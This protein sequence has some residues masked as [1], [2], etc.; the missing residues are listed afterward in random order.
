MF[1]HGLPR[2]NISNREFLMDQAI[3]GAL[4]S[5][6]AFLVTMKDEVRQIYTSVGVNDSM[7]TLLANARTCWDW[8]RWVFERAKPTG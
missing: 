3:D 8:E 1:R 4:Q 6:S 7:S 5:I 2:C